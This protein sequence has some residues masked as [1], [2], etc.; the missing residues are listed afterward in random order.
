MIGTRAWGRHCK[1][2]ALRHQLL[3]KDT[4]LTVKFATQAVPSVG[5][6][7]VH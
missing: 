4:S 1:T 2:S 3:L 7:R 5:T 6:L